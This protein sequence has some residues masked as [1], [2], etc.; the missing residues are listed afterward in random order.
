MDHDW[1]FDR[2][3]EGNRDMLWLSFAVDTASNSG[4]PN[5]DPAPEDPDAPD[6]QET[7]V[8]LALMPWVISLLLHIAIVLL[9][10]FVVW[11]V[12]FEADPEEFIVPDARLS[13]TPRAPLQ[14]R[15]NKKMKKPATSQR[16]VRSVRN[17]AA[18][19]TEAPVESRT[20][21]IGA[22][23]AA[24]GRVS[25]FG[26]AVRAESGFQVSFYGTGGNA[27]KIVYVIDASG[28]LIDS[29]DFVINELKR[30]INQLTEQQHFAVFFFQGDRV[31]EVP[32]RG[33]KVA[34]A[35]NK[36]KVIRWI[37]PSAGNI[38]AG[39]KT[40]PLKAIERALKYRPHLLFLLSDNITG[41]GIYQIDQR[42]LLQAIQRS[43]RHGTK[44]N[45]FQFL[46]PDPLV[47][48]GFRSTMEMI[49]ETT[50]GRYK[51]IDA[52]ELGYE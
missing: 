40:E 47:R 6:K 3:A 1:R 44:I 16:S 22:V 39:G 8:L 33:M 17:Q 48:H 7:Q 24:G 29:L 30:S 38:I 46:Y 4:K 32:S 35:D 27:K 26:T 49:A 13:Q 19:S 37:D 11:S 42:Q 15:Q 51:F 20:K 52:R 12:R 45:T 36:E 18:T 5:P 2:A 43:N 41:T 34:K 10:I 21:V 14:M 25:P 23:G 31:I 50:G 28:S 9:A